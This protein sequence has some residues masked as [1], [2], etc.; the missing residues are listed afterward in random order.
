M[1]P[2]PRFDGSQNAG[3]LF[4]VA[5]FAALQ[6]SSFRSQNFTTVQHQLEAFYTLSLISHQIKDLKSKHTRTKIYPHI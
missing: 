2:G 5:G 6:I 3:S 1:S 4:S